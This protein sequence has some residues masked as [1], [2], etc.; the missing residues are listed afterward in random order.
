MTVSTFNQF[1][2]KVRRRFASLAENKLFVVAADREEVWAKYLAAFPPGSN[3][4]FRE[5]TE[6]DCSCCKHFIRSIGNVVAIQNGMLS[7]IWDVGG[8]PAQYQAVADAMADY[9]RSLNI[10][11]V[12]YAVTSSYGADET[13]E[14]TEEGLI[15]WRH[16]S[17]E[18]PESFVAG[19][20]VAADCGRRFRRQSPAEGNLGPAAR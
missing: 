11:D 15:T 13:P 2:A 3:P 18:V 17:V 5:R 9:I 14:R 19:K 1:A 7:T 10:A 4:I 12:F 20:Q 16:F 6:H 8:L